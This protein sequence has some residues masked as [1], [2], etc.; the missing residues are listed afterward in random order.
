MA[1]RRK[2]K[3]KRQKKER[4]KGRQGWFSGMVVMYVS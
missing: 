1:K 2:G 3:R 4:K